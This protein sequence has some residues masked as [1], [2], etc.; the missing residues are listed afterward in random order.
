MQKVIRQKAMRV[1]HEDQMLYKV[2]DAYTKSNRVQN[3][4]YTSRIPDSEQKS[5]VVKEDINSIL[6]I[7]PKKVKGMTK[8][9]QRIR[10]ISEY[11]HI[12]T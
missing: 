5:V 7:N 6:N 4:L 12:Y 8:V 1:V 11:I 9:I 3:I 10:R 2:P